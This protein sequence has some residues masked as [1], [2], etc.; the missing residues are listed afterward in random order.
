MTKEELL[1]GGCIWTSTEDLKVEDVVKISIKLLPHITDV[2]RHLPYIANYLEVELLGEALSK[3]KQKT[4]KYW[5]VIESTARDIRRE[6]ATETQRRQ[7]L[8][9]DLHGRHA[10]MFPL[11]SED[12]LEKLKGETVELEYQLIVLPLA[13]HENI[14][15]GEI[16]IMGSIDKN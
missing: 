14:I 11:C 8:V 12:D 13:P 3:H 7:V 5:I 10:C 2:T 15:P 16:K 6:E 1:K 4:S 9:T